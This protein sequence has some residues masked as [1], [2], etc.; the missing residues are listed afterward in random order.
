MAKRR[1]YDNLY[2]KFETKESE[3]E[4]CR[5]TRQRDRTGKDVQHVRVIKDENGNVMVDSEA[6]L[7]RWKEYFEKLINKENNRESRKK[8]QKWLTK[9]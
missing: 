8:K 6:V 4:L 1:A 7:K 5:L 9:R 3:K 2:A